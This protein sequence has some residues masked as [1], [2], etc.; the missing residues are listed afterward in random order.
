[1]SKSQWQITN[2][3]SSLKSQ[4][5]GAWNFGLRL[6]FEICNLDLLAEAPRG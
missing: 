1:M 4:T 6:S 3:G 2:E 5:V